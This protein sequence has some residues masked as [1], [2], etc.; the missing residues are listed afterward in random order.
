MHGIILYVVLLSIYVA[1]H[2]NY[3][4]VIASNVHMYVYIHACTIENIVVFAFY[5]SGH[6]E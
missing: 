4:F 1:T 3:V 5:P 6:L 2:N